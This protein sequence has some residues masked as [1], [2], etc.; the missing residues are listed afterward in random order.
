MLGWYYEE[1]VYGNLNIVL[2]YMRT[3]G[4]EMLLYN[5][6]MIIDDECGL[7]HINNWHI[8]V[9]FEKAFIFDLYVQFYYR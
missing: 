5:K 1:D 2:I 7:R 8:I 6:R 9:D 3:I 4:R